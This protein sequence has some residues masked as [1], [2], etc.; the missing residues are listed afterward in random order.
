MLG[1]KMRRAG[2]DRQLFAG[3]EGGRLRDE[4]ETQATHRQ[5][6]H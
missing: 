3:G 4:H 5:L 6:K 1:I 2:E